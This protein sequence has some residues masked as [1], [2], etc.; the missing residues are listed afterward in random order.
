MHN[1]LSLYR[2]ELK[3]RRIAAGNCGN[4]GSANDTPQRGYCSKCAHVARSSR[5]TTREKRKAEQTCVRCPSS[6]VIGRVYC[7]VHLEENRTSAS[8]RRVHLRANL[9]CLR[10]GSDRDGKKVRCA[11]CRTLESKTYAERKKLGLCKTCEKPRTEGKVFCRDCAAVSGKRASIFRVKLRADVLRAYGGKCAC[12]HESTPEFLEMDHVQNNGAAHRREIGHTRLYAWLKA[13]EFPQAAFQILCANCNRAK[14][15]YGT[16][17][18]QKITRPV[19][20]IA[21]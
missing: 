13:N 4:C 19:F 6:A 8:E 17:P 7:R 18:H 12:C 16:C 21:A 20:T 5:V 11:S 1:Q 10:C 15:R 9:K 3:A 2:K 14:F